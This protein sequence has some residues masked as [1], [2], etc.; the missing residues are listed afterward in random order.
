MNIEACLKAFELITIG[1]IEKN[2][3]KLIKPMSKDS[4]LIHM[5]GKIESRDEFIKDILDEIL[6][7]YDYE[8]L[9]FSEGEVT[10]RLLAKVYGGSKSW[11]TLKMKTEY[12]LEDNLIKINL[13][14]ARLG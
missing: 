1:M 8:I 13:C 6:N 12:V 11:W 4:C 7:Y 10:I 9:S 3:E 14:K 5:T 2:K